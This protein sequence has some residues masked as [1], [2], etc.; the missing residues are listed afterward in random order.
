IPPQPA[1]T[2]DNAW[3][4]FYNYEGI[5]SG[6]ISMMAHALACD[7]TRVGVIQFNR[8]TSQIPF[9][10]VLGQDQIDQHHA[11]THLPGN[12][13]AQTELTDVLD[14]YDARF[15]ELLQSL[16]A[17]TD[18]DGNTVLDNTIVVRITECMLSNGHEFDEGHH[19]LAGGGNVITT[20]AD[21]TVSNDDPLSKL[22]LTLAHAVGQPMPSIAGYEGDIFD[23]LLV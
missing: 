10:H 12:G 18:I 6:Q 16:E 11:L 7:L 9:A 8:S 4:E 23:E 5:A 19:L 13:Q 3:N 20:G 14:W 2:P 15:V 21:L 17:R 1:P 22:W